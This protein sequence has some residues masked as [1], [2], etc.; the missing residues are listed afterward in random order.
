MSD[1]IQIGQ[2]HIDY[3]D[4]DQI[5][6]RLEEMLENDYLNTVAFLTRRLLIQA[7]TQEEKQE[8]LKRLDLGII[9]ETEL[10]E[11][12]GIS[13]GKIY[14][15]VSDRIVMDRAFWQIV[16][17]GL[18]VYLLSDQEQGGALLRGF[19]E[20]RYPG[21][22]IVGQTDKVPASQADTDRLL[23]T[24][25]GLFPDLIISGLDGS[26]QDLFLM[27]HQTKVVGKIWWS[28]GESIWL[29]SAAGMRHHWWEQRRLRRE[30]K[31]CL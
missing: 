7:Q 26:G 11:A 6:V 29:Q 13:A 9:D 14:E 15:E 24:V 1:L 8:Y 4:L 21:I 22:R 5:M 28:F 27:Q 30:F 31:N 18:S 25:N 2:F 17:R 20:E 19:L 10:L 3:L 16:R 23:N 12:A